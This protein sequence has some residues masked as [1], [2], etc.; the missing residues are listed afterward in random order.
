MLPKVTEQDCCRF[1]KVSVY[2]SIHTQ[3]LTQ[4]HRHIDKQTDIE[5][6]G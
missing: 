2:R 3:R 1:L 4:A 6:V 5:I